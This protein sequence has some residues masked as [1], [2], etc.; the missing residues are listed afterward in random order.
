MTYKTNSRGDLPGPGDCAEPDYSK[1]DARH[2][3]IEEETEVVITEWLAD[4]RFYQDYDAGF[5]TET[6]LAIQKAFA[7]RDDIEAGRLYREALRVQMLPDA[8]KAAEARIDAE[9]K[10][11]RL[12]AEEER[13]FARAGW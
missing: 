7:E 13:A 4:S 2:S 1:Q 8:R 10:Q 6:W 3:A 11:A 12:D 9:A 5:S